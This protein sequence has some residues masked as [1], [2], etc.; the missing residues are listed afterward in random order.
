MAQTIQRGKASW[1]I[2]NL[3]IYISAILP[4]TQTFVTIL[5]DRFAISISVQCLA[6]C[7]LGAMANQRKC[8]QSIQNVGHGERLRIGI[9]RKSVM[10]KVCLVTSSIL[11]VLRF[12]L[13]G[14]GSV[15]ESGWMTVGALVVL[16]ISL[17]INKRLLDT[18]P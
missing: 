6:H 10:D 7:F 4:I 3:C 5:R 1:I 8:N 2:L 9:K 11:Q 13:L 16:M 14:L 17:A 15:Y 18:T 12:V